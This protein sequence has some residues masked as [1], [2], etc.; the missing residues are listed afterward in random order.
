MDAKRAHWGIENSLHW[1]LDL[2]FRED[3][4]RIRKDYSAE[5]FNILRQTVYNILKLDT[6]F[7][8]SIPSKQFRCILDSEYLEHLLRTFV[9]S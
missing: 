3:E 8:A 2:S 6:S 1:V 7:H 4:S 9:C 5:N